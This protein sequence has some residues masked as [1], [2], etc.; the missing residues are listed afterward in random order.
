MYCAYVDL[1]LAAYYYLAYLAYY[2]QFICI[3]VYAR[4]CVLVKLFHCRK[5]FAH[6][7]VIALVSSINFLFGIINELV[8]I[9]IAT[10][11]SLSS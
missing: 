8:V 9:M 1:C 6:I 4:Q 3:L 7:V 10:C 2:C 11:V 5:L